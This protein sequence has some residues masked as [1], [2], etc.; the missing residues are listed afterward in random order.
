M[1]IQMTFLRGAPP[2]PEVAEM[3]PYLL[4]HLFNKVVKLLIMLYLMVRLV[5][6]GPTIHDAWRPANSDHIYIEAGNCIQQRALFLSI[7]NVLYHT[8][9]DT[10]FGSGRNKFYG[11]FR[12]LEFSHNFREHHYGDRTGPVV[13]GAA[14]GTVV[15][16]RM[17]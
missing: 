2:P 12:C 8:I 6:I 15:T 17:D 5:R 14:A 7:D 4:P 13:I 1:F 16:V 10:F 3:N 11:P 9:G